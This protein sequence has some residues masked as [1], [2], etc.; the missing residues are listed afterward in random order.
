MKRGLI[1]I[2][3]ATTNIKVADV[4]YNVEQITKRRQFVYI[5]K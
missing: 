4:Q 3:C 5:G 1:N 2:G